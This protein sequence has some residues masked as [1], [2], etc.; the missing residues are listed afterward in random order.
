LNYDEAYY[1]VDA[2]HVLQGQH[3]IF[4]PGNNGHEPLYIYLEAG[5]FKLFGVSAVTVRVL[6]ALLGIATVLAVFWAG[7]EIFWHDPAPGRATG[8]LSA[9]A[10]AGLYWH[11]SYSRG[12]LRVISFPLFETLAM[13]AVARSLRTKGLRLRRSGLLLGSVCVLFYC[14]PFAVCR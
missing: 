1:A 14:P 9:L 12:G 11:I 5:M 10:L 4:F 6:S 13:G 7:A 3:A 8:L 2:L